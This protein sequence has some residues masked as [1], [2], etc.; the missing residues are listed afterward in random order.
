MGILATWMGWLSTLV[1]PVRWG[2]VGMEDAIAM[3]TF[4][5][6]GA[7][8]ILDAYQSKTSDASLNEARTDIQSIYMLKTY[9]SP[10]GLSILVPSFVFW[11]IFYLILS[12]ELGDRSFLTTL[13]MSTTAHPA[14]VLLGTIFAHS[15]T[16]AISVLGGSILSKVVP[17]VAIGYLSG[18][19]F[20]INAA[21]ILRRIWL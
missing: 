14:S 13:A 4:S 3:L 17:E 12:A 20:L 18:F 11:K 7:K 2:H 19:L 10:F 9:K 5:Y 16:A 6:F 15:A 21:F 8:S 1:P